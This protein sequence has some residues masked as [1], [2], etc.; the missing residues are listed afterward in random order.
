[1]ANPKG[2]RSMKGAG[3][4]MGLKGQSTTSDR[5]AAQAKP[6]PSTLQTFFK[7]EETVIIVAAD[8]ANPWTK[9]GD[10]TL[11]SGPLYVFPEES[12]IP[13]GNVYGTCTILRPLISDYCHLNTYYDDGTVTGG[14]TYMGLL[15]NPFPSEN[16]LTANFTIV[17]T[18]G[19]F[20]AYNT[21][22]IVP[23]ASTMGNFA[24]NVTFL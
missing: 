3:K 9:S 24:Q 17:G 6:I 4:T 2:S 21:G 23:F 5:T 19:D 15:R 12:P 11:F 7:F 22:Y 13:V 20:T 18:H 16:L 1:M 10:M 14:W 8:P